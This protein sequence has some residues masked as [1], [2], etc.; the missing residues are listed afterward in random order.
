MDRQNDDSVFSERRAVKPLSVIVVGAGIGGLAVGLCM[1]KTGH[2]VRILEKRR[3]IAEVGAGIQLAPN[4]TR[5]LR[6][7]D[8]LDEA[9]KYAIVLKQ[10]SLRRWED[11]EEVG[12]IPLAHVEEEFGAPLA[13]IHRADLHRVL[14]DAAIGCGC[15]ILRGH[16]VIDTDPQFLPYVFHMPFA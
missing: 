6:R 8:V 12:S 5:I 2:K 13:V 11:D 7:F 4:A 15:E 16:E 14:L 3:E 9:M 1:Q 10:N